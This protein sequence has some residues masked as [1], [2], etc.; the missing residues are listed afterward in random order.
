MANMHTLMYV[1]PTSQRKMNKKST[2]SRRCPVYADFSAF[3]FISHIRLDKYL[4]HTRII[5]R[6]QNGRTNEDL[7][8]P[9]I[10]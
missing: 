5:I 1:T 9:S 4:K 10:I 8:T 2:A 3:S 7:I 6:F